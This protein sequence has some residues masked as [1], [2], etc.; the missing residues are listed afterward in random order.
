LS[1]ATPESAAARAEPADPVEEARQAAL[2]YLGGR[3]RSEHE[4]RQRLQRRRC[5]PAVVDQVVERLKSAGLV[6]DEA[7]ARRWIEYRLT[8]RPS[9]APRYIQDLRRKGIGRATIDAVLAEFGDAVGSGS[10]AVD[11]LRR[12]AGRYRGL[13]EITARR[14][15]LGVLA[16]RGFDPETSRCAVDQILG[17]L[18]TQ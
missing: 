1:R 8:D 3:D 18:D 16:R 11:L 7:L 6:D 17:E 10:S 5:D 4:I 15:M 9:G 14:R 2:R 13:D 12:V